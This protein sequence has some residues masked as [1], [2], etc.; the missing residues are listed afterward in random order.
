MLEG[1]SEMT[2]VIDAGENLVA[3]GSSN[4]T[5]AAWIS[6]DG[7]AWSRIPVDVA[8][9]NGDSDESMNSVTVGGPGLVAVGHTTSGDDADAAVWTSVDGTE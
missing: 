3:V 2:M 5:V 9:S 6:A 8:R 7:A 4:E 1:D